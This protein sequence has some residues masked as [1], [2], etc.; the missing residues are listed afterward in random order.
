M[1]VFLSGSGLQTEAARFNLQS[2]YIHHFLAGKEAERWPAWVIC[3]T[4]RSLK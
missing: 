4:E 1:P 2:R 3:I